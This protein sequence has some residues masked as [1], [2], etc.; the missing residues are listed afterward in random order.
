MVVE[1]LVSNK[2]LLA[3]LE[4]DLGRLQGEERQ[5]KADLAVVTRAKNIVARDMQGLGC[6]D[7]PPP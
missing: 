4:A 6:P 1:S 7:A 3:Q 5:L 2:K